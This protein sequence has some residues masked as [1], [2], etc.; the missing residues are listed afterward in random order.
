M[1]MMYSAV[2]L[3]HMLFCSLYIT[4]VLSQ[5]DPMC[6]VVAYLTNAVYLVSN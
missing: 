5:C 4:N 3:C 2:P 6:S 1:R